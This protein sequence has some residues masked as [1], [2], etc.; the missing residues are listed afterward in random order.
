MTKQFFDKEIALIAKIIA[1]KYRPEK[2]ILFGSLAW[3][4]PHNYS[5]ADLFVIKRSKERRPLRAGQVYELLW[6]NYQYK[7][8]I[9][10]LVY[11]PE[12][13]EKRQII[14][15]PFIKK[16]LLKGKVLYENN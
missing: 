14:G 7:L 6:K 12:E 2:I 10:V 11:T 1:E 8:P 15:D 4:K 16:I 9:D 3:G 5:D 13:I